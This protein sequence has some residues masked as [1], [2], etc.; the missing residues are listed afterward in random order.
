MGLP[1]L[2]KQKKWKALNGKEKEVMFRQTHEPGRLGLSDFTK[3]K[4]IIITINGKEFNHILYHFRLMYS[5]WSYIKAIQGGESYTALTEGLQEALR[6][7]GG[8]PHIHRTDSL[9][10]AFKNLTKD[11]SK[12]VTDRYDEFCTHYNM[13]ATRNNLGASHENGGIESPHGHLKRRIKQT[14]LLRGSNDFKSVEEYQKWLDYVVQNHNKRNAKKINEEKEF[15]QELPNYKTADF[16]EVVARVTSSSTISVAR[17]TYTVPSRLQGETL[18]VHMYDN[19]LCCYLGSTFAITLNRVYPKKGKD[20]A[21]SI[22]YKHVIDSLVKKPQAFRYSQIRDDLLP[23]DQYRRIWNHIDKATNSK[24]AC[25]L[26]V[27]LLYLAYKGDC[28]EKLENDVVR[29]IE[30]SK[31]ICL[32]ALQNRYLPSK[33]KFPDININQHGLNNYDELII[34]NNYTKG[35]YHA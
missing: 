16:T 35:I 13:K 24:T 17:I 25:K 10:A 11:E 5:G 19:K 27:G 30:E 20:R 15:L 6:R 3:L 32:S 1:L 12:D 29:L 33:I 7:L 26:I 18:R 9:S 28:E 31:P 14:L 4:G 34:N 23:N 2:G 21:R 8:S 22:N